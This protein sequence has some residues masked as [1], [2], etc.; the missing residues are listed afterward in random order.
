MQS[1]YSQGQSSVGAGAPRS[2]I[3][4]LVGI[5]G[6]IVF[7]TVAGARRSSSALPR[8]NA[9]SRSS[10][11]EIN[12][13]QP[14]ARQMA[15]FA[16]TPGVESF[17][18]LRGYAFANEVQGLGDLS[19]AAPLDRRMG[20]TVDR[21]RIISGRR[22]DPAAADEITVGASLA[23]RLHLRVGSSLAF[24]SYTQAQIDR[25]FSGASPRAP[26]GPRV[27]L[28]V[29]GI[30]LRPLD[31]GVRATSGG[32]IVLT[33]VFRKQYDDRI[34]QY[35]D[36]LRVKTTAGPADVPRVSAAAR[37]IFGRAQVFGTQSL[38]IESEGAR[39]AIDV[40]T[41][42]LWIVAGV[43]AAAG[44]VTIGIVLTR[45]VSSAEVDQA[46]LRGLGLTRSQR[47]M[48]NA[49]RVLLIAG[50][51]ALLAVL[52]AFA[53]S[54]LFPVGVA[55][56]ADPDPGLHLDWAVLGPAFLI[57][58]LVVV[59]I[60]GLAVVRATRSSSFERDRHPYRRTSTI[61]ERAA[62]AGV[63]P[64]ATNG[65]RM[66]IQPG[67][68]EAR[69]PVRSAFGGAVLGVAGVTAALVF[70][71][72]LSHL[73][74]T[75]RL[76]GWTWDAKVEVDAPR[77]PCGDR[78]DLGLARRPGVQAVAK[79]C[80]FE[81][82]VGNRPVPVWGFTSL[83]GT[84][85]P[86]VVAGRAPRGPNEI[87]LG[88]VTLDALH[89]RIGDTVKAQGEGKARDYEIV[90]RI[91]LPTIGSPQPLADGAAMT[92]AGWKPL[93]RVGAN[94]TDFLLVRSEPGDPA[95][96]DRAVER[97][98]Q[99]TGPH[100]KNL[101]TPILPVE[102]VRLRQIDQIP[103]LVAALLGFFA[104][105]AVGYALVTA[106]R[107]RRH[108]LAVLKILGFDRGQVRATVAWQATTL[109]AVGLVLGIPL[110]IIG[111]RFAW[112]VVAEGLGIA[113]DITTPALWLVLSVPVTLLFVNLVAFFPGRSAA[114]TAPAVALRTD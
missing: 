32:V 9:E 72:S 92:A 17:A 88:S 52:G 97:L 57:L 2:R 110:G 15:D 39:N 86:E 3:A 38:G 60:A 81:M 35:S 91:V 106:V 8:F 31:L 16:R 85:D 82:E 59:A 96:A 65:L 53:L 63:R 95:A 87:A 51:G 84:I 25:A 74:N 13:G 34:G 23:D 19:I 62:S 113:T 21:S 114:R 30:D 89:K 4:L 101:G 68:G 100:A 24:A 33:P 73:V 79:V 46:T 103:A 1:G 40:L 107:R 47:V 11:V 45:D 105:L 64:T 94:E 66:A 75:P 50:G 54:P 18:R 61:V 104:L 7:A 37:R 80:T 67:R 93:Y 29:V 108:E 22:A 55:R 28:H 10:D 69:V 70:A 78:G 99:T 77:G 5:V 14:T 6:A 102:I 56:R 41:L 58:A 109:G 26:A 111:G 42:A 83:H 90:G 44:L 98:P 48:A 112:Q 20:R 36:V 12:V 49:P 43:T 71:A 76:F 27:R